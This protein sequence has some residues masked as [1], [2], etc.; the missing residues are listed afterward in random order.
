MTSQFFDMTSTSNFFDVVLFLLSGLV[1][2][3]SSM[4]IWSVT[5]ELWQLSFIRDWPEILKNM[6]FADSASGVRPPDCSKLAKNPKNE[7]DVTIFWHDVNV[8]FFDVVLFLLSGLVTGPSFMSISSLTLE[9]WQLSFIVD[10]PEIW[11]SEI[12]PSHLTIVWLGRD[13]L[14]RKF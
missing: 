3:P 10:W 12:T 11:I 2:G 8:K 9:L 14:F 7:N 5:L 6:T 1:T 13:L 4:S